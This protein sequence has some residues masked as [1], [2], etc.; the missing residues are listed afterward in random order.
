MPFSKLWT[1]AALVKMVQSFGY[2]EDEAKTRL[3][4]EGIR[5]DMAPTTD[6]PRLSLA[7][8]RCCLD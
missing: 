3:Q 4:R 7:V 5:P 6:S 1:F 2:T 8:N